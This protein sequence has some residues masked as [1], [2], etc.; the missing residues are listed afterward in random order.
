MR[1]SAV[2]LAAMIAASAAV[3]VRPGSA[4]PPPTIVI[5][6]S[7]RIPPFEQAARSIA[8][9]VRR[10]P[11]QPEIL[12]FD[13]DGAGENTAEILGRVRGAEP[14][15]IVT[16]GSLATGA[17][18][19]Q[20]WKAPI[21]FSMVLYPAQSGFTTGT[22]NMTGAS[23]DLPLSQQFRALRRLL[24]EARRVGVLYHP[25]ETGE[26]VEA[27]RAEARRAGF[28]LEAVEVAGPQAALAALIGLLERVDVVW[29]VAD[30]HVF[31]PQNTSALILAALRARVPVFGLST[32]QVRTGAVAALYCDYGDVGRQTGELALRVLA[33]ERAGG[34][35]PT[36]PRKVLLALNL[37][38]ARHLGV[39]IPPELER[40]AGEVI[41]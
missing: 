36:M 12:T 7:S 18:L 22:R 6:T 21:V 20:T 17:V 41:R 9:S 30:S 33:G 10:S 11:L 34:I 25:E 16:V 1:A 32:A 23:L 35:P 5:L 28:G 13:L 19:A 2:A 3:G 4:T 14:A 40:D 15:L 24:P 26:I 8:E 38:A 37:R 31:T 29:T 27:A 39:P